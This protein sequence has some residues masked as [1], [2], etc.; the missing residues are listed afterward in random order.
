[1]E[2][3]S[4]KAEPCWEVGALWNDSKSQFWFNKGQEQHEAFLLEKMK[5]S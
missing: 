3:T 5:Q 1:M 4:V 2:L